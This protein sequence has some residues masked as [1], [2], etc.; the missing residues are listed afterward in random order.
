MKTLIASLSTGLGLLT[1]TS[2]PAAE[3][4]AHAGYTLAWHDEFDGETLDSK[5]WTCDTGNGFQAGDQWVSGWGNDELEFYTPRKENVFLKD[6]QLHLRA[7]RQRF[8]TCNFTSGRVTTR[9]LFE[10][11][12]GRFEFRARLP[13]GQ[14]VWPAL[15]M[16]P[17]KETY[18]PWAASGEIDVLEARGQTPTQVV[19]TLHFGAKWPGNT[20]AGADYTLPRNGRIDGWHVYAVEWEPGTVRWFVDDQKSGEVTTWWSTK[21]EAKSSGDQKPPDADTNPFPAPFDKPFCLL[22]N[23][24]VGGRFLGSPDEK[25]KFPV[26][27]LVDYVR[28]YQKTDA[29]EAGPHK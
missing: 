23:V 9:G 15:W 26:E 3:P 1:A 13:V 2:S 28:V 29:R 5:K 17:A 20:H 25:T 18:G 24:A 4:A 7:I 27:M 16:L 14:G 21:T 6:G 11:A 12:Y 22:M 10:Q 19:H 8:E